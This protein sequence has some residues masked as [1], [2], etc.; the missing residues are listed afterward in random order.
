MYTR[1]RD[2]QSLGVLALHMILGLDIADRYPNPYAALL[3][4]KD[5]LLADVFG[6]T[7]VFLQ[8]AGVSDRFSQIIADLIKPYKKSAGPPSAREVLNRLDPNTSVTL[9]KPQAI[10]INGTPMTVQGKLYNT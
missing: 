5:M 8:T 7:K 4:C 10:P 6:L 3:G 1:S 9:A 2:M